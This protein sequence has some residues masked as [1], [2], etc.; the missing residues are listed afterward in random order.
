MPNKQDSSTL[1]DVFNPFLLWADLGM[2][3]AEIAVASTQNITEGA[4]R[5]TRAGGASAATAETDEARGTASR[6]DDTNTSANDLLPWPF[7]LDSITSMQRLAWDLMAQNW[8]RWTSTVSNLLAASSG[9]SLGSK[10]T[11]Q[12]NPLETVRDSLR[13]IGWGEKPATDKDRGTLTYPAQRG[14]GRSGTRAA[15]HAMASDEPKPRRKPAAK[16]RRT[17]RATRTTRASRR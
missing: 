9:A 12:R 7:N 3:A 4:D 6:T 8:T 1:P 16:S 15:Q 5:L 2:R 13:P 14:N 17:S 10:V 11:G